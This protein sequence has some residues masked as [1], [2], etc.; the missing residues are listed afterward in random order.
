MH[1]RGFASC[2][3]CIGDRGYGIQDVL[4]GCGINGNIRGIFSSF[5]G[6]GI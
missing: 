4:K 2:G 3:L 5:I 6:D 1:L